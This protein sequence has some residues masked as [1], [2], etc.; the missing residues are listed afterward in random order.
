MLV[1]LFPVRLVSKIRFVFITLVS[2]WVRLVFFLGCNRRL[3]SKA[4]TKGFPPPPRIAWRERADSIPGRLCREKQGE[5]FRKIR[6]HGKIDTGELG[7]VQQGRTL[8]SVARDAPGPGQD[9]CSGPDQRSRHQLSFRWAVVS[10]QCKR[11]KI[12]CPSVR[13]AGESRS[14]NTRR[15]P[16]ATSANSIPAPPNSMNWLTRGADGRCRRSACQPGLGKGVRTE[17]P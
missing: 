9:G 7:S 1:S 2:K 3:P 10:P 16:K 4:V 14:R 12:G 11:N 6:G 8:R 15:P 13:D 17:P 5:L